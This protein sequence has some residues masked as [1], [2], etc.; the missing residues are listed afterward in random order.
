M[1]V[2]LCVIVC[3]THR[4]DLVDD[5]AKHLGQ[6]SGQRVHRTGGGGTHRLVLP[7]PAGQVVGHA[8]EGL[9]VFLRV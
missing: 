1:F 9:C 3:V 6:V 5:E 2:C 4:R 8:L 7:H